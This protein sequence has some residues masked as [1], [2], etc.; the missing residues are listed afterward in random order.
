[1]VDQTL[2]EL[3]K[4]SPA[5]L[6]MTKKVFYAW[7]AMHFDKGLARAEK[8]YLDELMKT[9]D[10]HEG[11]RAFIAKA[12]TEMD[13]EVARPITTHGLR[14]HSRRSEGE[15]RSRRDIHAARCTRTLGV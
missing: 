6:A 15:T 2:Q 8:I 1:M 12:R 11:I 14:N 9:S 13:R 4:L 5:A 7:D 10:A 3:L